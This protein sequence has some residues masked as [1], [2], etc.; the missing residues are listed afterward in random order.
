MVFFS[1]NFYLITN[2]ILRLGDSNMGPSVYLIFHVI[3]SSTSEVMSL[4]IILQIRTISFTTVF[5]G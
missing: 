5:L 3:G 2:N 4:T 1:S